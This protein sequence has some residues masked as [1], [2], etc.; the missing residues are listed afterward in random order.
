MNTPTPRRGRGRPRVGSPTRIRTIPPTETRESPRRAS[1]HVQIRLG[2]GQADQIRAAAAELVTSGNAVIRAA[3]RRYLDGD[4]PDPA[5]PEQVPAALPAKAEGGQWS[6]IPGPST[7]PRQD[8]DQ[9]EQIAH[10]AARLWNV[11]LP[12]GPSR[13]SPRGGRPGKAETEARDAL[14]R[15]VIAR[16]LEPTE[17]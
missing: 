12:E 7:T 15:Y 4:I 16:H 14:F 8:G 1:T 5:S 9:A 2:E 11:L 6:W 10:R 13:P 17:D 3:A